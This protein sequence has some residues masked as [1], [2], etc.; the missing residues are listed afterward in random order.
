[1]ASDIFDDWH[2]LMSFLPSR[3]LELAA[4][5]GALK[6]LRQDKNPEDLLRT[7]FIHCAC[8]YSLRETAVRA[9][10]A[11]L[12]SMSDVALLKRFKKCGEWFR[13][14]CICLFQERGAQM[15]ESAGLRLRLFDAT[16]VK[17]PGPT[18]SQ[19]RIHY[20]L[21]LPELGC[22]YFDIGPSKGPGTGESFFRFPIK[23]GD[24]ILADR[25]YCRG[26]AL[27]YIVNHNAYVAVRVH[28]QALVLYHPDGAPFDLAKE[29]SALKR[30]GQMGQWSV[31]AKT[32]HL[33]GNLKGRLCVIRKSKEQ[34]DKSQRKIKRRA[35][36]KKGSR[37]CEKTLFL[38]NYIMVFTTFPQEYEVTDILN[39]YRL[40]WQVELV[41]KRFKQIAEL[42]HLPK[43][44]E[45]SSKAWLYGKLLVALLVEKLVAH[46]G[47]ISPWREESASQSSTSEPGA[48]V[49]L[50]VS[51]GGKGHTSISE[52]EN[53][54]FKVA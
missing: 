39:F 48:G 49:C 38:A 46:A 15:R 41:F 52:P 20:S 45:Q 6:G 53:R 22:D 24:Y 40:R 7:M 23:A 33:N 9:K 19:W 5:T 18:G 47:A 43:Y 30:T 42:G 8:G 54:T 1:M 28:H 4:A 3:W 36:D 10:E 32:D 11:G 12:A 21:C 37:V 26:P 14:M 17:E 31:L 34:A 51:P 50:Y 25:A 35:Q 16:H 27:A 29:V 13:Q 2:E 44:D